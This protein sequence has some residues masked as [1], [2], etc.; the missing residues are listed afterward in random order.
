MRFEPCARPEDLVS[1][2]KECGPVGNAAAHP[3][4]VDVVEEVDGM[5][6]HSLMQS[7]TS[8][9]TGRLVPHISAV[10]DVRSKI[11]LSKRHG[12][13]VTHNFKFGGT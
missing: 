5:K 3:A 2:P 12:R 9:I 10:G 6:V 13:F 7:S 8:L 1:P 4:G 11:T